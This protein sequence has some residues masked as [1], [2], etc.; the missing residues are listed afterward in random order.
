MGR[1]VIGLVVARPNVFLRFIGRCFEMAVP[2]HSALSGAGP[3]FFG[4]QADSHLFSLPPEGLPA[5]FNH[6]F[7]SVH[8]WT[9]RCSLFA[10]RH[11]PPLS[12]PRCPRTSMRFLERAQALAKNLYRVWGRPSL[13]PRRWRPLIESGHTLHITLCFRCE[14]APHD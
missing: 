11:R 13:L 5:S 10:A 3:S 4:G 12:G 7:L 2:D 6:G 1:V 9:C 8:P 14:R